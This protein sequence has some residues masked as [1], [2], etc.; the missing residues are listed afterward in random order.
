MLTPVEEVRAAILA[1]CSPLPAVD[2][3]LTQAIATVAAEAV[4]APFDV[5]PF[6]NTAMDG[7]AVRAADTAGAPVRLDV[8]GVLPAG[9]ASEKALGGG[10]ALRIMTGAPIPAGADAVVM[11]ERTRPLDGGSSVLIEIEAAPGM[12][13]RDAGS[14]V[15]AGE[16]VLAAGTPLSAGHLGLL[17]SL[18][19][20]T[21]RVHRRPRVGVLVTG[22]E[23]VEAAA[24]LRPG[25]IHDAN[26]PMLLALAA[27]AGAL[28][29]D[30]GRAP[31]DPDAI[32]SLLER[33]LHDQGC[34]AVLV[35]GGVSV[36][37][38][39]YV[40]AVLARLGSVST[41]DVAMKPGK[42]LAFGLVDGRQV[43][44]LPGNPVSAVVSFEMFARPAVR[45]MLGYADPL[46]PLLRAV[47]GEPIRRRP[48]GKLHV[49]RVVAR[50]EA[51]GRAS[52]RS[53]GSQGSHVL[54]ALAA[55][56][57]LA[58]LPDGEGVE[59]GDPVDIMLL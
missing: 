45:T 16:V 38:F 18:G 11:V 9:S 27:E 59:A 54:A 53:A 28:S 43:F 56:N 31:D 5:P 44:G 10:Q 25:Q 30:L 39:D 24:L 8:V 57:A 35:T 52:I 55:A 19:Y 22:D 47:A 37:D 4:T 3:P 6:A 12:S 42:P 34:D 26:R 48:D 7:Y 20:D 14:D 51:D 58:L 23:L 17:A 32:A 33:A 36:G 41:W 49:N 21:V 15:R 13:I 46:R 29:V 1:T 50:W 40:A 2:L